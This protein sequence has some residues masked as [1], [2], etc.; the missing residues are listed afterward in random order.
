MLVKIRRRFTKW[1]T[2]TIAVLIT[3]RTLE[4][5]FALHADLALEIYFSPISEV[6][7]ASFCW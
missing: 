5:V 7:K 3:S 4:T 6:E 2:G 1:P